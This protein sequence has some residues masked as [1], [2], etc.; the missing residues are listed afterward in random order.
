MLSW[1]LLNLPQCL[2]G[3]RRNMDHESE[4]RNSHEG[5]AMLIA[6]IHAP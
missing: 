1:S 5:Y 3:L 6:T 2:C 4:D